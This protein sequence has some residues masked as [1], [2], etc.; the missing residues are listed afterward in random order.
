MIKVVEVISDT[1]IGGAGILLLN[2]LK[3]TRRDIFDIT[4]ILPKGSMLTDRLKAEKIK[5]VEISCEGDRSADIKSFFK[6][7]SE[8]KRISPNII[9]C[10][11]SFNGRVAAK[12]VGVPIRIYT[13]HCVFPLKSYQ[14]NKSVRSITRFLTDRL[15]NCIIAVSFSARENL[16]EMGI[17]QNRVK[18]IINGAERLKKISD[19]KREELRKSLKMKE[20]DIVVSICARLEP[21]KDHKCFL[22]AARVLCKKSDKYRF[23]VIGSGSLEKQLKNMAK[24]LGIADKIIF[25]G[26][27]GDVSTYMNITDVNVNCSIGT[28]TSSLA[29]SEGMSLGIPAVVSNYGGNPYMVC[30]GKNGYIYRSEN[31]IELAQ[32]IEQ[33]VKKENYKRLSVGALKR[34]ESELNAERMT[35][36]TEELYLSL[37]KNTLK[38]FRKN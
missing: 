7:L 20:D 17:N 5:T 31:F 9:N 6:Y 23:L 1:N 11:G 29:L 30:A 8:I 24:R 27:V 4:V 2:R 35:R 25:T 12:L 14:K 13:R 22:Q 37:Y 26:F 28:E 16:L 38:A 36:E 34:F 3:R 19:K 33:T 15:N 10:H 21:C 18:V 32:K